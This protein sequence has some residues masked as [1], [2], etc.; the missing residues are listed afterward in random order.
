MNDREF[1]TYLE[2]RG[3]VL[4]SQQEQAVK[5]VKGPTLLLAVPGSGKTTTLIARIG[6]MVH[7]CGIDP[8]SILCECQAL[9]SSVW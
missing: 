4:N 5:A 1:F 2:Q 7:C 9:F 3:I 8:R 6:Y